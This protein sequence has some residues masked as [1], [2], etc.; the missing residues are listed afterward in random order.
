MQNSVELTL[1]QPRRHQNILEA[2]GI[3]KGRL[4]LFGWLDLRSAFA[5]IPDELL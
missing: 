4:S 3:E 1:C 5:V 2:K